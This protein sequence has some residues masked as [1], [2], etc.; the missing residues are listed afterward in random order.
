MQTLI[1]HNRKISSPEG[2]ADENIMINIL[3]SYTQCYGMI[4]PIVGTLRKFAAREK[5]HIHGLRGVTYGP[6]QKR[7]RKLV[8]GQYVNWQVLR[9]NMHKRR[10]TKFMKKHV[11]IQ[12]S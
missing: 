3:T 2:E 6:A 8:A 5:K 1:P 11:N 4:P 9:E 12:K 10:Y 7:L